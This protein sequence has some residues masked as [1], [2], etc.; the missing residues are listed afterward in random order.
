VFTY[1]FFVHRPASDD[2]WVFARWNAIQAVAV[3][4][5]GEVLHTPFFISVIRDEHSQRFQLK[6]F[7]FFQLLSATITAS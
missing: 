1:T 5:F 2:A 7:S 4:S 6:N 3:M